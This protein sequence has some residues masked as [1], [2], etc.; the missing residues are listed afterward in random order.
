MM[1]SKQMIMLKGATRGL[2]AGS[3][4]LA[5][6]G[7]LLVLGACSE[8]TSRGVTG[9]VVSTGALDAAAMKQEMSVALS[10]GDTL[11]RNTLMVNLLHRLTTGNL[12]GAIGAHEEVISSLDPEEVRLFANA[13]ARIDAG[14]ALDRVTT[15]R[16]P[17]V[18]RRAISEIVFYWTS[19]G[20]ADAARKYA[21]DS[22]RRNE[23]D[24]KGANNIV[25]DSVV[26]GLAS[27][28]EHEELTKVLEE[29]PDDRPRTFLITKAMLQFYRQGLPAVQGWV[30]S[31]PWEAKNNLKRAALRSSM[32][33]MV[34]ADGAVA[35]AW[36][37][38]NEGNLDKGEFIEEF[39]ASWAKREPK[40]AIDW[41]RERPQSAARSTALRATAF[42]Y[43]MQEGPEAEAWIR[44]NLEDPLIDTTMRF[45]LA[46]YLMSV[47]IQKALPVA[48]KIGKTNEK[49][50][51]LKQILMMWSRTDYD[52]VKRY[53]AE[54]GVP[55]DVEKTVTAQNQI[56]KQKRA[57]QS[58]DQG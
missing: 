24:S 31:I 34:E 52:A 47:D 6:S 9:P 46:Q 57:Q 48:V 41:L 17:L 32:V 51:A 11:D 50:N 35:S 12:E 27:S 42:R 10:E 18:S 43:L 1:S 15:W 49:S 14:G 28:G 8:G 36:F 56:R 55:A 5:L 4:V 7:A 2:R 13:W 16:N 33:S 22:M 30:D 25:L 23:E 58:A 38:R 21:L 29:F 37:A 44:E 3:M 54:V 40:A 26:R 39:A 20:E 45:P 53:M 19:T